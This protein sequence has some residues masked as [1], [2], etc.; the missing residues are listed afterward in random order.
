GNIG[1]TNVLRTGNKPLALTTLILDSGKGAAAV[2]I[3]GAM[4]GPDMAVMAGGGAFLGHLFPIYLKFR[5]GKGVATTL[6]ILI[7]ISWPVGLSVCL[8]WAVTALI[9]RISSLS[10]LMALAASPVVAWYLSTDQVMEFSIFLAVLVWVR[11]HENIRRILK[12]EEPGIGKKKD[13]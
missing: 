4:Y 11:H 6:G 8:T 12:G 9:F 5:G 2:L 10:G 3:G 7:A 1:A 13:T